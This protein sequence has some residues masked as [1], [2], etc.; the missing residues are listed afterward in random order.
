MGKSFI[1]K[2]SGH[3]RKMETALVDSVT[4]EIV[5]REE[6]TAIYISKPRVNAFQEGFMTMG[7][8]AA[9]TAAEIFARSE[10]TGKDAA[11]LFRLIGILD[12]HN[13]LLVNQG[14]LAKS[15]KLQ[16]PHIAR[17][18]RKLTDLEIL[19]LGPKAGL[20]RTYRLNPL[21]GWKGPNKKHKDA[22]IEEMNRRGWEVIEGTEFRDISKFEQRK[23]EVK[24][25]RQLRLDT[26]DT[27]E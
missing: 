13:Y 16:Q 24:A 21:F 20:H 23:A 14:D 18:L 11:V 10:L 9:D 6:G 26:D 7:Q 17:S 1:E 27:Q 8:R 2:H 4:G 25:L 19:I 5:R 3:A 12:M 22:L 15:L